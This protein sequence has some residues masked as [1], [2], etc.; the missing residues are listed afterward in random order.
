MRTPFTAQM[1]FVSGV[2]MIFGVKVAR[3][4]GLMVIEA[5]ETLTVTLLVTVT[6]AEAAA[7]PA[8]A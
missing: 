8:V 4:E 6:A 2:L 7:A 3:C 5:G 1:T